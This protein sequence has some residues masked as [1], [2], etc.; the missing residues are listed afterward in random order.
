MQGYFSTHKNNAI[1][2]V[3]AFNVAVFLVWKCLQAL[4]MISGVSG[5]TNLHTYFLLPASFQTL[6][7]RPWTIITYM[8]VHDGFIHLLFNMLWLH[9][10]GQLFNTY[11]G[12]KRVWPI[13]LGG[14]ILGAFLFV[15]AYSVFPFLIPSAPNS[16]AAGSSAGVLSIAVATAT[17]LPNYEIE[18]LLVGW[19]RLKYIV[20][21][22]VLFDLISIPYNN[23]GGHLAHLGGALLGFI[24]VKFLY[25]MNLLDLF[26]GKINKLTTPKSKLKIHYKS[27]F[28]K[29]ENSQV[30]YQKEIDTILDKINSKGIHSLSE[31][32]K[33]I[34]Q[35][36]SNKL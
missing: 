22:V 31:T 26:S 32:E 21:F 6:L 34:L 28:M 35:K 4:E 19:V 7:Y 27:K 3:I 18:M 30:D 23:T 8:F 5:L 1:W 12:N 9:W 14:G 15:L 17:L 36:L 24:Y 20:L 11:M 25:Q 10:I 29:F 2:Q 13:Y 16:L 33:A